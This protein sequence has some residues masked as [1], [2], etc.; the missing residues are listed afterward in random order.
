MS[1]C[2]WVVA[3]RR[4]PG[5]ACVTILAALVLALFHD[6]P[7]EGAP[8]PSGKR[9]VI[10][11]VVPSNSE[12]KP[13]YDLVREH[14]ALERVQAITGKVK[15]PRCLRCIEACKNIFNPVSEIGPYAAAVTALI[16]P[17]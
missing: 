8:P 14:Q 16:E 3:M 12:H 2:L 6:G 7:V 1:A 10:D 11:Y 13:L 5:N 9:V 15:S 4:D 17:L